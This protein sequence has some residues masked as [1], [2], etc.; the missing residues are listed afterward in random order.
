MK[1]Y[2]IIM[3]AAAILSLGMPAKAE[4]PV[5]SGHTVDVIPGDWD[6]N[7]DQKLNFEFQDIP[8][9]SFKALHL[10]LTCGLPGAQIFY[11]T[12]PKATPADEDAWSLYTDPIA[13]TEDC[14]IRF[15][16]RSEGYNDSDVQEFQFIFV[17]HQTMAPSIA[18]DMDRT[19]L[20]MVTDTPDAVI[21]YTTDGSEPTEESTLYEGPVVIEANATFRAKAFASDM[22][23]SEITDYVVDFLTASDP[24]ASFMNKAIVLSSDDEKATIRYTLDAEATPD[25]LE[26]WSVYSAPIAL[27]EDAALRFFASREG[28]NNSAVQDFSFVYTEYQ[29]EVPR[30]A[31]NTEGTHVEMACDTEGASIHYTTDGSEPTE[32]SPLYSEPV[33]IVSNGTF[34]ARAFV[35]GM[36]DSNIA[37]FIVMHLAVPTPVATFENK[38]LQIACSDNKATVWYTTDPNA[39]PD[40]A[41]AWTEYKAPLEL[42]ENCV[43]RF[44]GRRANFNDSDIQSFSFIYSN[45]RVADPTIERNAEGTH[46]VMETSTPNAEIRYT[47]DGSEP[48]ANSALYTGPLPIEGNF[49]YNAIAI[50]NGMFDSKVNRYVVS[51]MAVPVPFAAFENKKIVLTCSDEKA[52]I[53]YTTNADATVEDANAWTVYSA[54]I[55]LDSDC[56]LRFY[57]RRANF[58]DSD[59]ESLTFVYSAYQAQAPT[60][61]RN[62]QGT[63]MVM[64]SSVENAQIRYTTDGS[65]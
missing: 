27:T 44:Y 52:Q 19:S 41:D 31:A 49:T 36:F 26:A 53:L 18:P 23:D 40:N 64:T 56:T 61:D 43:V 38:K 54:P 45:Y 42:T 30:L 15:F 16:A 11:T 57:T 22:F 21:R 34:R 7:G 3:G 4:E 50:A 35:D 46:I 14:T 9:A 59:I 20:V 32:K 37:D 10:T 12:D 39:T 58:N 25:N 60:I 6:E 17:D 2:I 51:N 55:T 13:L 5:G 29:V 8:G 33:E 24:T 28:Y 65:V 48:T 1:K 47:T 63:H 62:A